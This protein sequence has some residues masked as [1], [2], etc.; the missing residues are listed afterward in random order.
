MWS[1]EDADD[2]AHRL[3]VLQ[4]DGPVVLHHLHPELDLAPGS[5]FLRDKIAET[6][7]LLDRTSDDELRSSLEAA[8]WLLD[9]QPTTAEEDELLAEGASGNV[10][11]AIR[12]RIAFKND[13]ATIATFLEVRVRSES[14]Y[15]WPHGVPDEHDEL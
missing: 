3:V 7:S 13:L 9:A 1:F 6:W 11:R 14:D 10:L 8:E 4:P 2:K 5:S 15:R 12:Y